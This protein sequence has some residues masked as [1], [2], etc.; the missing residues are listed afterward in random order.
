MAVRNTVRFLEFV[1]YLG[2]VKRTLVAC[3]V[4]VRA[5]CKLTMQIIRNFQHIFLIKAS[6]QSFFNSQLR[7]NGAHCINISPLIT[8]KSKMGHSVLDQLQLN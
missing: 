2:T 4:G 5:V 1:L 6:S 7:E 8:M 3:L